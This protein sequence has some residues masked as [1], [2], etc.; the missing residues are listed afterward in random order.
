MDYLIH[1]LIFRLIILMLLDT[2][3]FQ[4]IYDIYPLLINLF[5]WKLGIL[6]KNIY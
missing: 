1:F 3:I 5:N 2:F 4:S 6:K